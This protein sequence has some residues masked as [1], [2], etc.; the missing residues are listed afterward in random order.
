[1]TIVERERN[2]RR[3]EIFCENVRRE[4][5]FAVLISITNESSELFRDYCQ[6]YGNST[7][8]AQTMNDEWQ[9][10]FGVETVVAELTNKFRILVAVCH[11][12]HNLWRR[13]PL[14]R[15]VYFIVSC[16]N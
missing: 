12:A 11:M 15:A 9:I 4:I 6:R 14:L 1:M 10:K 16:F 2:K 13:L 7:S 3:R 8:E 5:K